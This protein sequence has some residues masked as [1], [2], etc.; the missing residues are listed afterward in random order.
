MNQQEIKAEIRRLAQERNALLLAHNYQRDE[1]QE[2]ADI[3]G[4]SLG[5]SMEAAR[6]DKDVIVFCGVHFMAE[7]A[8]ILAPEKIVLLPRPDAGCPMADMVTPEGLRQLKARHPGVPVVTYVNSSAAVKAESDIC[9]TSA[10]AIKVVNSLDAAEVI[11]VPDRNLG[12]YIAGHTDKVCHFW[13]G[14]CPTHERLQVAD[15][16]RAKKDY[17]EA[18]FMAHP[19]C[20][21]D[22]LAMADHI[23]S[24][25][26]MYDYVRTSA[27]RQFIVG[28]E[29]GILYRLRRE[30]PD[31]E[32]ILP[33][34]RLICPNMK[35]TSLEDVLHS[36]QTLSPEITVPA[37]VREKARTAL[38][39]M[40]AVPRD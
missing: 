8:A 9:C 6:T 22:I 11:L 35:L 40:L 21:P 15:V 18:V 14:Y 17:P 10:N 20:H 1:I 13:E 26:G 28:T 38:D 12:R 37:D 32:F 39:R 16:E 36:L 2:I 19:E 27:D 25:S 34:S 24:T 30:N 29:A 33:T 31:R 5:L 4:D 7:S 3:T 23:C